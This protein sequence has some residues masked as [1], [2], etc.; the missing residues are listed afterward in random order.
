MNKELDKKIDKIKQEFESDIISKI[1]KELEE[2]NAKVIKIKEGEE[3][4]IVKYSFVLRD[5]YSEEREGYWEY[6]EDVSDFAEA[7]KKFLKYIES[8]RE[9]FPVYSILHDYIQKNRQ[10]TKL[11]ELSDM[12]YCSKFT[13]SL[14]LCSYLKLPNETKSSFGGGDYQIK[15]TPKRV[16]DFKDNIDKTIDQMIDAISDLKNLKNE[17]LIIEK[18]MPYDQAQ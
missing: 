8:L 16:K 18:K 7:Q 1:E 5:G 6:S 4:A 17:L 3:H 10:Y 14:E 13:L 2:Y 15:Q 11:I 9:K 12:G